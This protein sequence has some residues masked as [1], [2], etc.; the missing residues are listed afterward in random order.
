MYRVLIIDDE[1]PARETLK[2]LIDWGKTSFEISGFAKNGKEALESYAELKPD[3]IITDIQ[4]PIM[5]GLE[6][7]RKI[8][9][10]NDSQKFVILSCHENFT[11]A[12]EAIKYGVS[13]YL[14]KDL[15]T[16]QDLYSLLEKIK[17]EMADEKSLKSGDSAYRPHS[18]II[19]NEIFY[20]E[21]YKNAIL[22]GIAFENLSEVSD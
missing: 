14:L 10:E 1:E 12:R 11:Y 16:P 5:D 21:E 18:G 17:N 19:F 7:I 8:R 22:Q 6:L 3:L 9:T 4:M 15:L 20:E 2:Y 13:D